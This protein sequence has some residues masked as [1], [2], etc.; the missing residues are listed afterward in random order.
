[1]GVVAGRVYPGWPGVNH[2]PLGN[3]ADNLVLEVVR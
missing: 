3:I 2:C 1:M